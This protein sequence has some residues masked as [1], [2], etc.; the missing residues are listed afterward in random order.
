MRFGVQIL[1]EDSNHPAFNWTIGQCIHI[2]NERTRI[3]FSR[4]T[5]VPQFQWLKERSKSKVLF[6]SQRIVLVIVALSAIQSQPKKCLARMLNQVFL[7]SLVVPFEPTAHQVPCGYKTLIVIRH[8]LI[9][10]K[11]LDNHLIVRFVLVNRPNNPVSPSP[12]HGITVHHIGH[13]AT[14][15]PITVSPDIHPVPCPT[16]AML[17]RF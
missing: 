3:Y 12:N 15:V 2:L 16:F 7:P 13:R 14:T 6:L 8:Q 5:I 4:N 11:H 10:R 9:S 1:V 17:R